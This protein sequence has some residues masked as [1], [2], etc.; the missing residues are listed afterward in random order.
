MATTETLD[1]SGNDQNAEEVSRRVG[2]QAGEPEHNFSS[3]EHVAVEVLEGQLQ[4][5]SPVSPS[6]ATGSTPY[7]ASPVNGLPPGATNAPTLNVPHPKKFSHSN[8]NKKFLEK[9]LSTS[10]P[11]SSSSVSSAAKVGSTTPK[12]MAQTAPSHSRLVTTKL[13]A[14]PQPSMTTGPG[15]SRPP[16]SVSSVA[17]TPSSATNPKPPPLLTSTTNTSAPQPAPA[18]KVIQPQP[19]GA[20]EMFATSVKKDGPSRPAWGNAKNAATVVSK[21]DAV[22]SDFPTAAEV[23]QGRTSRALEIKEAAQASEVQKQALAAEEDTFR[24]VHLDPKAHHWDEMEEDNDDFLGGVIEFEDGRQYKV[25]ETEIVQSAS[26]SQVSVRGSDGG[27]DSTQHPVSKEER[28]A[29]DFDRSWPRSKHAMGFP[30]PRDQYSN[31]APSSA[32]SQSVHSPQESSRVLFNERSNRLEPY[33]SAH[34]PHRQNG[35]GPSSFFSRRDSRS[36]YAA[37]P[38]EMRPGR[39]VPPHVHAPGVQ[40]LQKEFGHNEFRQESHYGRSRV[41]GDHHGPIT[42][43]PLETSRFRDRESHRRDFGA[44]PPALTRTSSQGFKGRSRDQHT[45][46]GMP[47]GMPSLS[48]GGRDGEERPRQTSTMGPPPLPISPTKDSGPG[49][50]LPP[51][52]S[53][54][55]R[56][57]ACISQTT[58]LAEGLHP[59]PLP[60]PPSTLPPVEPSANAPTPAGTET[61]PLP[62]TQ[63]PVDIDEVRKAVMHNA[64]ERAR[65]RRQQEEEEREKEKERARKKA[66][67]LEEK[68][69]TMEKAKASQGPEANGT[70]ESQAINVIDSAV[71]GAIAKEAIVQEVTSNNADASRSGTSIEQPPLARPAF[72]QAAS[73]KGTF[74]PAQPRQMSFASSVAGEMPSPAAEAQ[75]WRSRGSGRSS[76]PHHGP[77]SDEQLLPPPLIHEVEALLVNSDEDLEVVDFSEMGKL[78]D[79]HGTALQPQE[80]LQTIH[81]L[82]MRPLRPVAADFFGDSKAAH[83]LTSAAI[84]DE[85]TWRR[86][87]TH[88]NHSPERPE[89]VFATGPK[90]ERPMTSLEQADILRLPGHSPVSNAHSAIVPYLRHH[91]DHARPHPNSNH[92]AAAPAHHVNGSQRSPLTSSYREAP[93][94]TLDDTLSRIKGALDGMHSQTEPVKHAKWLPPALRLKPAHDICL[95]SEVFDVT[96]FEPPKSP[97]PAWNVYGVKLPHVSRPVP[98][99]SRQQLRSSQNTSASSW[100]E[101]Y[102]WNSSAAGVRRRGLSINDILFREPFTYKRSP[103]YTVRLPQRRYALRPV[104][105]EAI[106]PVVNLPSKPSG[107]RPTSANTQMPDDSQRGESMQTSFVEVQ[108]P[109]AFSQYTLD[110]ISRSPPPEL[111]SGLPHTASLPKGEAVSRSAVV[112]APVRSRSQPKMPVGSDVAF[113]RDARVDYRAQPETTVNFIVTSELEDERSN[114]TEAAVSLN[115]LPGPS[116]DGHPEPLANHVPDKAEGSKSE[117]E[118]TTLPPE[119]AVITPPPSNANGLLNKLPR[120]SKDSSRRV[121]DREHLKAVWS[122]TSDKADVPS[123]NSL[124]GIADDLTAVPFTL[125]EVKSEDGET[126]PPSGS[127]PSSRMSSHDVIRAFQQVPSPTVT[128]PSRSTTLPPPIGSPP[129]GQAARLPYAYA[130]MPTGGLRPTYGY[131]MMSQTP[132]PTIMYPPQMAPSPVPRPMLVNGPPSPYAQPIWMPVQGPTAPPQP[133][134]MMRPIP[135]PYPAQLLPYP[136]HGGAVP[137]YGPPL[138]MQGASTQSNGIQGRASMPM[139]S[140]G[141]QPA[142]PNLPMYGSS[143]VLMHSPSML[144]MP[145]AYAGV[146][147]NRGQGREHAPGMP[148]MSPS[149]NHHPP[150]AGSYGVAPNSYSRPSW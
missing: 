82:S 21:L 78:V 136:S 45:P 70:A 62:P 124:K 23:A 137:V 13:T 147:P 100:P 148:A 127:G 107:V 149:M 130:P 35:A 7:R 65:I 53:T 134:T 95:P 90:G 34:P 12:P 42:T 123:V 22:A 54:P 111:L 39:D 139:M 86:K 74:R 97:K 103:R 141:L 17:P 57:P 19:R 44:P 14:S 56:S 25:E 66:A 8:I 87:S 31:G 60:V 58:T 50:E 59:S 129:N 119:R 69:K 72:N 128:S 20:S 105:E 92:L 135:S 47:G 63:S 1:S 145:P 28:F 67:E 79:A 73:S 125:H 150:P 81:P 10:S 77:P 3:K 131:P 33:S 40:L 48:P 102:S 18:G 51:H 75:S 24:G 110:T 101:I 146:L 68:M 99:I 144:P 114:A 36:D 142:I 112:D 15:W 4:D 116:E 85:S 38:S 117:Q 76:P 122:Q 5:A 80:S 43:S 6:S 11:G 140:P 16:S 49:R 27:F 98:P 106:S 52:M 29:D 46:Y 9:T 108:P 64:V 120:T 113:Y 121:P 41:V 71:K 93:M 109:D 143:P 94:S 26:I 55:Q 32:S 126:P 89:I 115:G 30:P 104:I 61:S 83:E 133:A 132:S 96:G 2:G 37:P 138:N 84:T 91:D 88:Q 118:K